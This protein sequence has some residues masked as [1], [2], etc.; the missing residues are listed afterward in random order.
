MIDIEK[1]HLSLVQDILKQ[2]VSDC[3]VRAFG[4]RVNGT[5]SRFSD[6]DIVLQCEGELSWEKLQGLKDAFASS[7]LP[8]TVDVLDWHAISESFRKLI[9]K[10]YE[11]IQSAT[12][13]EKK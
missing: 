8:I 3:E 4:S 7:D 10:E 6:L 11:V 13:G 1:E 2:H 12:A 9:S 5:A